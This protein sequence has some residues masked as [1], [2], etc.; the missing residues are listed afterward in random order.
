MTKSL[1]TR[2][3]L[4]TGASPQFQPSQASSVFARELGQSLNNVSNDLKTKS[5]LIYINSFLSE[6]SKGIA[7]IDLKN[8]G[9]SPEQLRNELDSYREG[10]L[11]ETPRDL[12][13][14]LLTQ[15]N[16]VA[17]SYIN[18]STLAF[19]REQAKLL[20]E[21][22][23][24][25]ESQIRS[26]IS[27]AQEDFVNADFIKNED[28][29]I[30]VKNGAINT[31]INQ[32]NALEVHLSTLPESKTFVVSN[33]IK[34]SLLQSGARAWFNNQPNKIE[35]L[36]KF[37]NN[38]AIIE[39][40]DENKELKKINLRRGMS[41][42]LR[43]KVEKELS[44]VLKNDI[45]TDRRQ[46]ELEEK[47]LQEEADEL[48]KEFFTLSTTGQ[49][50]PATVEASKNILD[51]KTFNNFQRMAIEA[52][53]ITNGIVYGNLIKKL[54][55]G[56]DIADDLDIA[57]FTTKS[58]SNEDYEKLLNKNKQKGTKGAI[59]D[60]VEEGRDF[61]LNFLG[62]NAEALSI[63]NSQVMAKAERDFNGRV[64]DFVDSN[65]RR[66]NREEVFNI[67]DT[68]KDR[69]NTIQSENFATTLPKPQQMP[70]SM[71]TKKSELTIEN[72]E[73]V[74]KNTVKH[75]RDKWQGDLE[76]MK[77]DPEFISEIKLINQ[78]NAI[79][80]RNEG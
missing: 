9:A 4:A 31:L 39:L 20:D 76:S 47:E 12:Q 60:S 48:E 80:L 65:G 42:E 78:Y 11:E 26:N 1:L 74:K 13:Q 67:A 36:A 64:Q 19:S 6:A 71:K 32:R 18:R 37:Q 75:F 40:P 52:S 25:Y 68:V 61:L 22:N 56:V 34:Q 3:V 33:Q 38:E 77:R 21:K 28:E 16:S 44:S 23:K 69:W 45:A 41:D 27:L 59:P 58:I 54:D 30:I 46:E 62:S 55:N 43:Q 66:P 35:A 73:K 79:V 15:Y 8:Q 24:E 49:L 63:T 50:T 72:L 51:P 14:K 5:D 2:S 10:L 53:P 29:R 57:R 17:Q 7:E 70:L